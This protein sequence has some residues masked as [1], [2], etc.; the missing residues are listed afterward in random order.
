MLVEPAS[1]CW[2]AG[3]KGGGRDGGTW[4]GQLGRWP[5]LRAVIR[6]DGTGLGKG[7]RLVNQQRV[8]SQRPDLEDGL[9]VFPLLREAGRASRATWSGASRALQAAEAAQARVDRRRVQ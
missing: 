1:L 8:K 2:L 5:A 3:R 6:D 4:G 9:D 7:V